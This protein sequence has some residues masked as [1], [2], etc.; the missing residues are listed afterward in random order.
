[1]ILRKERAR[2]LRHNSNLARGDEGGWKRAIRCCRACG[3]GKNWPAVQAN[4]WGVFGM[5]KKKGLKTGSW[6]EGGGRKT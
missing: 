3:R 2:G 4:G 5:E 6:V 1:L